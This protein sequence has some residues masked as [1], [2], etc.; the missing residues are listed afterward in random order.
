M[1]HFLNDCLVLLF[2]I[3]VENVQIAIHSILIS[4]LLV[5]NVAVAPHRAR[6]V[7]HFHRVLDDLRF[8]ERNNIELQD[9]VFDYTE[10][11]SV[12]RYIE[13][14]VVLI[15]VQVLA[16]EVTLEHIEDPE[17][18][19]ICVRT[20]QESHIPVIVGGHGGQ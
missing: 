17:N 1:R 13:C 6:L 2:L 10:P 4:L 5:T 8:W 11:L 7:C 3:H 12:G 9:I 15:P 19:V 16:A 20:V 18:L 14:L